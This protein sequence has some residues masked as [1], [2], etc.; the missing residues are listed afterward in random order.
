MFKGL[1]ILAIMSTFFTGPLASASDSEPSIQ[2]KSKK[3]AKKKSAQQM[4]S[5]A[6]RA[7]WALGQRAFDALSKSERQEYL[8][9]LFDVIGQYELAAKS[10]HCIRGG[11]VHPREDKIKDL[12]C[13]VFNENGCAK[14]Q[15][16][17]SSHLARGQCV[18]P[19]KGISTTQL[20]IEASPDL[21]VAANLFATRFATYDW[22]FLAQ[23]A[24]HYCLSHEKADACQRLQALTTRAPQPPV[25][26]AARDLPPRW[27]QL[28][29]RVASIAVG[30]NT[31]KWQVM[32]QVLQLG[33][34]AHAGSCGLKKDVY[35][36][37]AGRTVALHFFQQSLRP[38]AEQFARALN[39]DPTGREMQR[40]SKELLESYSPEDLSRDEAKAKGIYEALQ[41]NAKWMAFQELPAGAERFLASPRE[42]MMSLERFAAY[43]K[44][45]KL[46]ASE[47]EHLLL[48]NSGPAHFAFWQYGAGQKL[49]KRSLKLPEFVGVDDPIRSQLSF[50]AHQK[51]SELRE[52]I[53]KA[54]AKGIL[55]HAQLQDFLLA[56]EEAVEMV[57]SPVDRARRLS[58][59]A[60]KASQFSS[61][62]AVVED[63]EKFFTLEKHAELI[64]DGSA[65][66][67]VDEVARL[68]RE[69]R[70]TGILVA[71]QEH[72]PLTRERLPNTCVARL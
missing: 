38:E 8:S 36:S 19:K 2:L 9:G 39:T 45:K 20:C 25:S 11:R 35:R 58:D 21:T 71:S 64:S 50:N 27:D 43:L 24:N 14:G 72:E 30:A 37:S 63:I 54:K 33:D 42:H 13:K 61:K 22:I 18:R 12:S 40:Y 7:E 10:D 65:K 56:H 68:A 52:S 5:P 44:S 16:A 59:L 49:K 57:S 29:R 48:L 67:L 62:P 60:S 1:A 28:D 31:S 26:R 3:T 15:V 47:V 53:V 41:K 66:F 55:S 6:S 51:A 23:A 70:G 69:R 32:S 46:K 4:R 17:C 34:R